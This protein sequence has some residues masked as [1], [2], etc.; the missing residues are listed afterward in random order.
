M[1]YKKRAKAHFVNIFFT[2]TM[3]KQLNIPDSPIATLLTEL[4]IGK[5]EAFL[6]TKLLEYPSVTVQELQ[7]NTPFPRTLLY[8]LLKNLMHVGLVRTL[9]SPKKTTYA[10]ENPKKI[11]DLLRTQEQQFQKQKQALKTLIP[12]LQN[13][14]RLAHG[15]PGVRLLKGLDGY[16]ALMHDIVEAQPKVLYTAGVVDDT[17]RPGLA[18]RN[19]LFQELEKTNTE[20]RALYATSLKS[21]HT[22]GVRLPKL[23]EAL[24]GELYIY[25][26]SLATVNYTGREPHVMIVQDEMLVPFLTQTCEHL[27]KH[28]NQ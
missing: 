6:Y 3:P 12:E 15:R 8:Y 28:T 16:E 18:I 24:S 2:L 13:T 1:V 25:A 4:H 27:W 19:R 21:A 26:W 9:E 14:F 10:A 20:H 22:D 7:K 11:L 17:K 5:N 23:F